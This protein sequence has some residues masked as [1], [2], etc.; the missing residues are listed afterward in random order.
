MNSHID[1]DKSKSC[2]FFC[3]SNCIS[4]CV[5]PYVRIVLKMAQFKM[6]FVHFM[7][8][9]HKHSIQ[10]KQYPL[11]NHVHFSGEKYSIFT[12]LFHLLRC[13]SSFHS[14]LTFLHTVLLPHMNMN[15]QKCILIHTHLIFQ[16]CK[17][18]KEECI[19]L[20]C[21]LFFSYS[22]SYSYLLSKDT[23]ITL[24]RYSAQ[25][26]IFGKFVSSLISSVQYKEIIIFP[27]YWRRSFLQLRLFMSSIVFD[28][29]NAL[30]QEGQLP[31]SSV[32]CT[33]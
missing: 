4:K 13:F 23:H 21:I 6:Y 8:H 18:Q 32:V 26:Y 17:I 20:S 28:K 19:W 16:E 14:I 30:H 9:L 2:L 1:C 22:S 12:C 3:T 24:T 31:S 29:L 5:F 25:H 10:R 33:S 11:L 27:S 7:Y 15:Y